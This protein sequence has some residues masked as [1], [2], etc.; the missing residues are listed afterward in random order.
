MQN[1]MLR[2]VLMASLSLPCAMSSAQPD[3]VRGQTL[4]NEQPCNSCHASRFKAN[5]DQMY[6]RSPRLVNTRAQLKT[7]IQFCNSQLN[8]GLFPDD[9]DDVVEF[10]NHNYYKFK[11]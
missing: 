8:A 6:L 11:P 1:K 5:P 2:Y 10:L 4:Y 3:Y 9:E 7:Q